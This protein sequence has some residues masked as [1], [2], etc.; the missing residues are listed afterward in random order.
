MASLLISSY[1]P[2]A[3]CLFLFIYN[4]DEI[5]YCRYSC[6]IIQSLALLVTFFYTTITL[7]SPP[8]EYHE[9]ANLD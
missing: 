4:F 2:L 3:F 9:M 6:G 8:H 5:S 7:L 1:I